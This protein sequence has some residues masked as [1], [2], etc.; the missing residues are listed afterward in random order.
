MAAMYFSQ[1]CGILLKLAHVHSHV[2]MLNYT[3]PVFSLWKQFFSPVWTLSSNFSL[4]P[5]LITPWCSQTWNTK[6]SASR[7]LFYW[8]ASHKN[9]KANTVLGPGCFMCVCLPVFVQSWLIAAQT[10]RSRPV[11]LLRLLHVE[12]VVQRE[13]C[14]WGFPWD[15]NSFTQSNYT[16]NRICINTF[17]VISVAFGRQWMHRQVRQQYSRLHYTIFALRYATYGYLQQQCGPKSFVRESKLWRQIRYFSSAK[18]SSEAT[19]HIGLKP[20]ILLSLLQTCTQ[21][22]L[23]K[24]VDFWFF[25]KVGTNL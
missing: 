7:T 14:R 4:T 15:S 11:L 17:S 2:S 10:Q 23:L 8:Q 21:E 22:E 13:G 19:S 24:K 5:S 12:L 25:F 3:S 6:T 20:W 18:V 1:S 9:R 16:H